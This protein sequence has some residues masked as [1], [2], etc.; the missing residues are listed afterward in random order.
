MGF[1]HSPPGGLSAL[2]SSE[3]VIIIWSNLLN[4]TGIL[5]TIR[6]RNIC[7]DQKPHFPK[8]TDCFWCAQ[9]WMNE[10]AT[11]DLD[12][13]LSHVPFRLVNRDL[14]AK[15]NLVNLSSLTRYIRPRGYQL[16]IS[17]V[18]KTKLYSFLA[19]LWHWFKAIFEQ[20]SL[21][22]NV[23]Q[24]ESPAGLL[25]IGLGLDKCVQHIPKATMNFFL[26]PMFVGRIYPKQKQWSF[27]NKLAL[28]N[29]ILPAKIDFPLVISLF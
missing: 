4:Q 7:I 11:Y 9:A 6:W 24:Q 23:N 18:S 14:I 17:E 28:P 27:W 26:L 20:T 15:T 25:T 2:S 3:N 16:A 5:A 21:G 1:T 10:N 12:H 8:C 22:M 29:L 13:R 19:F